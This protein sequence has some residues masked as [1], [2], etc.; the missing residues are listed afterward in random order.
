QR[1]RSHIVD[2]LLAL[3]E[4]IG[5]AGQTERDLLTPPPACDPRTLPEFIQTLFRQPVVAVHPGAGNITKQWPP[6][7]YAALIDLLTEQDGV[8]VLLIGSPDEE[9]LAAG[10]LQ[11]VQHADRVASLAGQTALTALPGILRACQLY[12]G[13]DSGPKHIA[14]AIGVPTLGIHSG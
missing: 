9:E 7:Y 14:A 4:T 3:V 10:V 6:E 8:N 13:N 12:I 5:T 2:D 11:Q 1:K